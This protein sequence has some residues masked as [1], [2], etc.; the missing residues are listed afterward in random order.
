VFHLITVL[1]DTFTKR[2]CRQRWELSISPGGTTDEISDNVNNIQVDARLCIYDHT[3]EITSPSPCLWSYLASFNRLTYGFNAY[4]DS[5][6][7]QIKSKTLAKCDDS[8][9]SFSG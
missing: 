4:I 9:A 6:G 3:N 5:P 1:L 2:I 8:L 7:A